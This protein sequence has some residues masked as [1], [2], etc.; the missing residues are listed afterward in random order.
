VYSYAGDDPVNWIDPYGLCPGDEVDRDPDPFYKLG[1]DL[2]GAADDALRRMARDRASRN[3][4]LPSSPEEA[5]RQGGYELDPPFDR[6]HQNEDGIPDHKWIIPDGPFGS[7]EVI[8]D[9]LTG[10]VIDDPRWEGT[11][12]Y[13]NPLRF[14]DVAHHGPAGP[15]IWAASWIGHGVADVLPYGMGY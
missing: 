15:V 13:V 9:G 3:S 14:G 7:K 1:R 5:R 2:A 10:E 12:N 6:Y 11:Y 8:F 4:D